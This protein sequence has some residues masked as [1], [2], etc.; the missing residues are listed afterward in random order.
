MRIHVTFRGIAQLYKAMNRKWTIEIDVRGNTVADVLS[1]LAGKYGP[2]I[3]RML[4][5]EQGEIDMELRV[6]LNQRTFLEY[7]QRMQ[8]ALNDGDALLIM[9]FGITTQPF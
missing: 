3:N 1:E 9:G 7:G 6:F 2:V 5:D 4:L 8:V